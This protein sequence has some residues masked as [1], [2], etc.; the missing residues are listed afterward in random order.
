MSSKSCGPVVLLIRTITQFVADEVSERTRRPHCVARCQGKIEKKMEIIF[1]LL[2]KRK[3]MINRSKRKLNLT[4]SG[5]LERARAFQ[6]G[7][8]LHE[9]RSTF[10]RCYC[11]N[12]YANDFCS[13]FLLRFFSVFPCY[14]EEEFSI[15]PACWAPRFLGG[16]IVTVFINVCVFNKWTCLSVNVRTVCSVGSVKDQRTP[17]YEMKRTRTRL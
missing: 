16:P 8:T 11:T 7:V 14:F 5:I 4:Q 10:C 15:G 17:E 12:A 13:S 3:S 6:L 9:R 1:V 2:R